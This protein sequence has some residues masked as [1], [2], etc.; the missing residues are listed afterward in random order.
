MIAALLILEPPDYLDLVLSPVEVGAVVLWVLCSSTVQI[1][2]LMKIGCPV[3]EPTLTT[4][5]H[6]SQTLKH[7]ER[8]LLL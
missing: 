2:I 6:L 1:L 7:R 5:E 3:K 4:L 8:F